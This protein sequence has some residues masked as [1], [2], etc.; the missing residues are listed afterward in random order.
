MFYRWLAVKPQ[1]TSESQIWAVI[2]AHHGHRRRSRWHRH[3]VN[4]DGKTAVPETVLLTTFCPPMTTGG[5]EL[6]VQPAGEIRFVV[7]CKIY[8][9]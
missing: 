5:E 9:V 7:D 4:S 8:L 1:P 3:K 2:S 6:V